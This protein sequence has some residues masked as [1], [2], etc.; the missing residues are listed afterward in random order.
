MTE[1]EHQVALFQWA[2]LNEQRC[3][4]LALLYANPLGGKR[5]KRT[6]IRMKA[7][8]AKAG[9]P[10]ITLPVPT[11]YPECTVPGLYIELKVGANRPTKRQ[12]WWIRQLREQGYQVEVCYGWEHARDVICEYLGIEP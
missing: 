8:G 4:A 12:Q 3:P 9:I 5:P 1:H 11:H 7:E 2:A 10:D 6:A